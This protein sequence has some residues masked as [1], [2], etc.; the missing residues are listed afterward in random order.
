MKR[1]ADTSVLAGAGVDFQNRSFLRLGELQQR[2]FFAELIVSAVTV[3][4]DQRFRAG[5]A[6][7]EELKG[8]G[9]LLRFG[10]DRCQDPSPSWADR[11]GNGSHRHLAAPSP[12]RFFLPSAQEGPM[13]KVAPAFAISGSQIGYLV[14]A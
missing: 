13:R 8:R 4:M 1:V 7:V 14:F 9:P 6:L 12:M 10:S 11:I 5:P 2:G 3:F